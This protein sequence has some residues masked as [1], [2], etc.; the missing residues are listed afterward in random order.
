MRT[1]LREECRGAGISLSSARYSRGFEPEVVDSALLELML[2][3]AELL[4]KLR[5]KKEAAQLEREA[6]PSESRS[7]QRGAQSMDG[8]LPRFAGDEMTPQQT[9]SGDVAP[10]TV[11]GAWACKQPT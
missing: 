10:V 8:R 1:F 11:V 3:K 9:I 4:R 5:R 6:R 2:H 7:K